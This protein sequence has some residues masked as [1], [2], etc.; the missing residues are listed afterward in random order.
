MFYVLSVLL[1]CVYANLV[2]WVVHK[3]VLHYLGQRRKNWIAG[4]HWRG[5]HRTVVKTRG[6][7]PDY[8]KPLWGSE[9]GAEIVGLAILALLHSPLLFVFPVFYGTLI[10]W[11]VLYYFVHR[12]FHLYPDWGMKYMPWH[13]DHHLG[14]DQNQN[15]GVVI[16]LCDYILG[17][18]VKYSYKDGKAVK[19]G[20]NND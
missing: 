13:Y 3:Y 14:I 19:H 4:A 20:G 9:R 8:L 17:T 16:P 15:W 1:G 10:M 12:H 18:R 2:E 11:L 6:A 7:D 5:H